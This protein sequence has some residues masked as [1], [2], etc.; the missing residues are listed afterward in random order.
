MSMKLTELHSGK[1]VKVIDHLGGHHVMERLKELG[2]LRNEI[3]KIIKNDRFGPV[4]VEIKGAN[5]ALGRGIARKI[6]VESTE[7]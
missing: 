1:Q 3:I 6:I 4:I 2:L 7:V 5:I